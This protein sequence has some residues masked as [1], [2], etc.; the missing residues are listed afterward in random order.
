M[1]RL[2]EVR[3]HRRINDALV[4]ELWV[5]HHDHTGIEGSA[6]V[7]RMRKLGEEMAPGEVKTLITAEVGD[8]D[9]EDLG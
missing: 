2:V 3:L 6:L 9:E 1:R 4:V 8:D 5:E 7:A